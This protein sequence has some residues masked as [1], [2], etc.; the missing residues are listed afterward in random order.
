MKGLMGLGMQIDQALMALAQAVPA[1]AE[2][3]RQAKQLIQAGL[4]KAL[5]QGPGAVSL[6][7]TSTGNQFPGASPGGAPPAGAIPPTQ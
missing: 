4:A 2:E 6:T 7:P 3:F 5:Q 1:G